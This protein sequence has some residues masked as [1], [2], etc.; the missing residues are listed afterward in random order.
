MNGLKDTDWKM[1]GGDGLEHIKGN[2]NLILYVTKLI[3]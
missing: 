2:R 3:Q 1:L